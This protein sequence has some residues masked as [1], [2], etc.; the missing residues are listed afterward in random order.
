[1]LNIA[2]AAGLNRTG[3]AT[4]AGTTFTVSQTGAG[5]A[6]AFNMFDPAS[7][8]DAATVCRFRG[9]SSTSLSTCQLASTSFTLGPNTI[10]WYIWKVEYTY[11]G[12]PKTLTQAGTSTTFSFGDYCGQAPSSVPGTAIPITA[13]L[14]VLDSNGNTATATSG[15]G[16]QLPLQAVAYTCGS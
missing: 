5:L 11:G 3:T 10:I 8:A 7:Q 15:V 6:P 12:V 9:A 4:I 16:T 14:S 1:M 13:T 2:S